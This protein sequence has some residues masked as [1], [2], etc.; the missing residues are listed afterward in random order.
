VVILSIGIVVFVSGIVSVATR[1]PPVT[2]EVSPAIEGP[3]VG[4]D[5]GVGL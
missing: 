1:R 3:L 2:E 4:R 5:E